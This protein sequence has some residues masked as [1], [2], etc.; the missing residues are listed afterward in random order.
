MTAAGAESR[1]AMN[2]AAFR[3]VFCLVTAVTAAALA[4]PFVEAAS[5]AG[6]FGPGTYTD[7]STIDVIPAFATAAAFA[8]LYVVLRA[9]PALADRSRVLARRLRELDRNAGSKPLAALFP[10][11]FGVQLVTLFAME[12]IEQI[13]IAGHPLG[14][15]LWLGAPVP[16]A[17][18]LHA[19]ACIVTSALL[20]HALAALTR[21]AVR[22]VLF[23]RGIAVVRTASRPLSSRTRRAFAAVRIHPLAARAGKRAP[24][25]LGA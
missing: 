17:L 22:I 14:G 6:L 12:T 11:I 16:I 21:A 3:G 20:A 19:L 1:S 9:R 7:R 23:V 8:V 4:D 18:A 10:S 2:R 24:P 13:A 5:N 15:T 25:F